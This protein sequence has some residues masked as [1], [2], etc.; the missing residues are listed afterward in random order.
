M[1]FGSDMI[2]RFNTYR[3][4]LVCSTEPLG[5][6]G[7]PDKVSVVLASDYDALAAEV[8]TRARLSE[9]SPVSAS[10]IARCTCPPVGIS[11]RC[12]HCFPLTWRNT[13]A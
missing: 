4:D 10:D 11:Y 1:S 2:K 7:L 9:P 12:R 5:E 6:M 8:A 3:S 13:H